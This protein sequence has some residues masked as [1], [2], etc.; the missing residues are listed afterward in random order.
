MS[1]PNGITSLDFNEDGVQEIIVGAQRDNFNAHGFSVFSFY[2]EDKDGV[3]HVIPLESPG[4]TGGSFDYFLQT[5][6]G[7]ECTVRNV[8]FMG[9]VL[10]VAHKSATVPVCEEGSV[11]FLFYRMVEN[12]ESAPGLPR[13]YFELFQQKESRGSFRDVDAAIKA[14]KSILRF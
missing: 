8:Y 14:E 1:V 2:K 11:L 10:L 13:W 9:D 4:N 12:T 6:H 5:A 3:L 7:A